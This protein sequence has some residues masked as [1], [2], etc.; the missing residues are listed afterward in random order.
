MGRDYDAAVMGGGFVGFMMGTTANAMA[1]ICSL[2][3]APYLQRL[4]SPDQR[5]LRF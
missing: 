3:R 4:A 2:G 5:N 1:N